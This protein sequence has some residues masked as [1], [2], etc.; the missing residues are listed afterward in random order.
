MNPSA[1]SPDPKVDEHAAHWA[2]RLD[3]SVLSATD[4]RKLDAWLAQHPD[5]RTQLSAYC[6]LSADLEQVLPALAGSLATGPS[7]AEDRNRRKSRV[8]WTATAALVAAAAFAL[9]AWIQLPRAQSGQHATASG[10]RETLALVDGSKIELNAQT[11]LRIDI[12]R[13]QR[14]IR[15]AS[16][17]A[18]FSVKPDPGRPF[19]VE[20]PSGSVRVT[21][22]RFAV[23]S[24]HEGA[25]TVL[26]EEG[27]VHVLPRDGSS[28]TIPLRAGARLT[29][30]GRH[31]RIDT[32]SAPA[33]AD[34]LAWRTGQIV[35]AGTPLAE[36][37][38]RFGRYH[39]R[40]LVASPEAGPLQLGGRYSLDDLNGFLNAVEQALPVR[41]SQGLNGVIEVSL[42][43]SP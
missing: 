20:T 11:N 5:H 39:G 16:G 6:Q 31:Q 13:E 36:A 33:L 10:Q 8:G 23:R 25:L 24:E 41:V 27:S 4:R 32:L 29:A 42:R 15:L 21:G 22:T 35:F 19:V 18:F 26:V 3:G 34:A 30:E 2:A 37:L 1:A 14:R 12:D 43:N 17:E 28:A 7:P 9:I 38:A 40:G